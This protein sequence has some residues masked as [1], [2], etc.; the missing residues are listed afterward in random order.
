MVR[1]EEEIRAGQEADEI[2]DTFTREQRKEFYDHHSYEFL[3]WNGLDKLLYLE[4][5]KTYARG[6]NPLVPPFVPE[7]STEYVDPLPPIDDDDLEAAIEH[8]GGRL[9]YI[10]WYLD[11]KTP[12]EEEFDEVYAKLS[13][14]QKDEIDA[15]HVLDHRCS[16]AYVDYLEYFTHLISTVRQLLDEQEQ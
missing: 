9:P 16:L 3:K 5:V 7:K 10:E 12:I 11:M 13:E 8:Y 2:I 4:F 6:E 15:I 1:S 14:K